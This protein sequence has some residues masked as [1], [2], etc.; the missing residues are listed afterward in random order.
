MPTVVIA[1]SQNLLIFFGDHSREHCR[2]NV[3]KER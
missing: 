2:E 3:F 1:I